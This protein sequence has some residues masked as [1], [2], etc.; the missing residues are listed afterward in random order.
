MWCIPIAVGLVLAV[1]HL[2]GRE[3]MIILATKVRRRFTCLRAIMVRLAVVILWCVLLM[4]MMQFYFEEEAD[5]P[6]VLLADIIQT[7]GEISV[8]VIIMMKLTTPQT[9]PQPPM[10]II[11]YETSI[12]GQTFG[13]ATTDLD[14]NCSSAFPLCKKAMKSRI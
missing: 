7:T 12:V 2:S 10:G 5:V 4:G 13:D 6:P 14:T 1:M 9:G 11:T 8:L 3:R